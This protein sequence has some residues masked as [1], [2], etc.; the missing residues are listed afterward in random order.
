MAEEKKIPNESSDTYKK[1]NTLD[2]TSEPTDKKPDNDVEKIDD[3]TSPSSELLVK[4]EPKISSDQKQV[5]IMEVHHPHLHH[6]KRWK[7]YLFEFIMLFLAITLGFFVENRREVYVENK[8]EKEY[9]KSLYDDL[10]VD[11]A[12]LQ[13][14]YGEK[15]WAYDKLDSLA[16]ILSSRNLETHNE[17][18]YYFERFITQTDVFTSQDVTYQ[19]L[20]N[21]GSFRYIENIALY[22]KIT[23]Y[24]NL[25]S[26]Y[27][28]LA[29]SSFDNVQNL[30]EMESRLFNGEDLAGLNNTAAKTFYNLFNRPEK[31]LRPIGN[32]T[33]ALNYLSI[34]VANAKYSILASRRFLTW[35]KMYAEALLINLK[36]EYHF[37]E[38]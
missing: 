27:Q 19:Q 20:R 6:K 13:R 14:T 25:Y 31:K 29:E 30:T 37:K 22:K 38:N 32:D 17:L 9:I 11:T 34:K 4:D 3:K 26:R 36:E 16:N 33:A 10:K 15:V 18:I 12:I 21:S 1:E 35:L 7:D 24:Y 2:I 5:E 23:D 28:Q 8:R